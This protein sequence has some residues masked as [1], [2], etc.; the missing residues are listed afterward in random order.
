MSIETLDENINSETSQKKKRKEKHT[1]KPQHIIIT[2]HTHHTKKQPYTVDS[3]LS[4]HS[5]K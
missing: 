4:A 2:H 3:P 5:S 1:E